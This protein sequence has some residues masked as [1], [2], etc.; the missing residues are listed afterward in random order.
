M[1]SN[2]NEIVVLQKRVSWFTEI[3]DLI[4][5]QEVSVA[6][7]SKGDVGVKQKHLSVEF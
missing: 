6:A 3:H 2:K 4:S 1:Y 5:I 7:A